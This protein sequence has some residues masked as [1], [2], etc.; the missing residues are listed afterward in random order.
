[1]PTAMVSGSTRLEMKI[2]ELARRSGFSIRTIRFYER[3]GLLA[4]AGRRPSGY[5][6]YTDVEVRRLAFIREA[7]ALGLTLA[8]IHPLVANHG[9]GTRDHLARALGERIR[10]ATDQLETL[11]E[12]RQELQ[13]RRRA[14]LRR[15]RSR[16]EHGVCTCLESQRRK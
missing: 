15:T 8:G 3:R 2:G 11:T 12:L 16:R 6:V 7:K 1:M 14:L 13:R 9:A 5:R 10:Q 4:P